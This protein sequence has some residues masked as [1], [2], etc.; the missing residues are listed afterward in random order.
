MKKVNQEVEDIYLMIAKWDESGRSHPLIYHL[1]ET[2]AVA[3]A[4]WEYGLSSGVKLSITVWMQT[5]E[6]NAI[7]L[8]VF[9]IALHDIG[10]A[11][12]SFQ[13]L[14][15]LT[16]ILLKTMGFIF[17]DCGVNAK[18][19]SLLSAW[20]LEGFIDQLKIETL[21]N[22][23]KLLYTIG[24]HHGKMITPRE[25]N[26][27]TYRTK[28][29]G[30]GR[31]TDIQ[32][33][34]FEKITEIINPPET[35][36]L[37][38][39]EAVSNAFFSVLSGMMITADWIASNTDYFPYQDP[40][41]NLYDYYQQAKESACNALRKLGWI[42]WQPAGI[43]RS[44]QEVFPG[45]SVP[46]TMQRSVINQL[47]ALSDPFL[48]ILEAPT[49]NGK[50]EAALYVADYWMQKEH[51]RGS[52]VA[53]PTQATSNQMFGRVRAYLESRYPE[54][55]INLQLVHGNA[56]IS[57]D[58]QKMQLTAI[59]DDEPDRLGSVHAM[60]WFTT[61]KLSLLAPFGVGTVD[62]TLLSVLHTRHF[63]LRLFGL[64]RKVLIFDEV[65]AYDVY[66]LD[67]FERLLAWLHA[68]GTSVIILSA[69]LPSETRKSLLRAYNPEAKTEFTP[70]AYPRLSL[71]S[72]QKITVMN[73]GKPE[74]RSVKLKFINNQPE[75][76]VKVLKTVLKDGGC[77]AIICNTVGRAQT[78]YR[79]IKDSGLFG[80]FPLLLFH[81]RTPFCYREDRE[82]AV[83]ASYG[84]LS[85]QP[86]EPRRGIVV[87]T[88]VIEQSLDL[89]FDFLISDLAPID[90]LIQRI[91]RLQRHAQMKFPPLRPAALSTP[92]CII[93]IPDQLIDELPVFEADSYVYDEVFLQ[94]TFLVLR[95]RTNF[96][97]P[98][99]SDELIEAV[100]SENEFAGLTDVQLKKMR[101]LNNALKYKDEASSKKAQDG[102]IPDVNQGNI[103]IADEFDLE[104]DDPNIHPALQ[105]KTR[106]TQPSVQLVC[107][108]RLEDGRLAFLDEKTPCNIE[109]NPTGEQVVHALKSI[110]SISDRSVVGN[111]I[112]TQHKYW[113][114]CAPLRYSYP[115]VFQSDGRQQ[116]ICQIN[117]ELRLILD[118]E[119]GITIEKGI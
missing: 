110:V 111:F 30:E 119:Y 40:G 106:D 82:K 63:V 75:S 100:Y 93:A 83:L 59:A 84:K 21:G 26:S 41:I 86:L 18:H 20:I 80:D 45:I 4:L 102:L 85:E 13:R 79:A 3:E 5:D 71:N 37:Q 55:R 52:Y 77:A 24:G 49:G 87:A 54:A 104:E 14:S 96:T 103:F 11:T 113:K 60:T 98:E 10:K 91:G 19:H 50:T 29:L 99:Q 92:T 112:G 48:M 46:N 117:P 57:E 76:I 69:T 68:I 15:Q 88:Q 70:V 115:V 22:R 7:R 36:R 53:M 65:H 90:L 47:D 116:Y 66:M 43:P 28:N 56:M 61:K 35:I 81:A 9:W 17:L 38:K 8:I 2:A 105:A 34:L 32:N 33:L 12:P 51:L 64:Y 78:V 25:L 108:I 39:G 109:K 72:K 23:R 118:Q 94:R 114:K 31:W 73:V 6:D 95:D 1:L 62:Q 58:F 107:I 67:I 97:L 89:D 44:F 42:G 27:M 16:A 74:N 101:K